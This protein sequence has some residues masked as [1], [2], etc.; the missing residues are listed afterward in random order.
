M[1]HL[2][3]GGCHIGCLTVIGRE[4]AR[5]LGEQ[6]R[7]RYIEQFALVPAKYSPDAVYVRS[8]NITRTI[9]SAR[10]VTTGLF[11]SAGLAVRILTTADEN[12]TLYPNTNLC[13]RLRELFRAASAYVWKGKGDEALV[14]S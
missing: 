12:E 7:K 8:T 2:L 3:P 5:T 14:P 13:P 4:D 1:R 9:E 11:G 10:L 6:L